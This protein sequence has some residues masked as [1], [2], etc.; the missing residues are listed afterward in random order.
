MLVSASPVLIWLASF[1]CS[2]DR[3]TLKW[4]RKWTIP[5]RNAKSISWCMWRW[6]MPR[7]CIEFSSLATGLDWLAL[8]ENRI[9]KYTLYCG[10]SPMKLRELRR[11]S[12][13]LILA[14]TLRPII[15]FMKL[16]WALCAILETSFDSP[17][18]LFADDRP[19]YYCCPSQ[20]ISSEN[21]CR[22]LLSCTWTDCDY[23]EPHLLMN[24]W[25]PFMWE[26]S[27]NFF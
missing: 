8:H 14:E 25:S 10:F 21:K 17:W 16:I 13:F 7:I 22:I 20:L 26:V 19:S 1:C 6:S 23:Q 24:H 2:G 27:E 18:N 3:G 12:H 9:N 11:S 5:P 4:Q 15:W